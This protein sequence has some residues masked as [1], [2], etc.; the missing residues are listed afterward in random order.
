MGALVKSLT[1]GSDSEL[2][3]DMGITTG[4]YA[5]KGQLHIDTAKLKEA[6]EAD[7][8]KVLSAFTQKSS[9]GYSAYATTEQT[10]QRFNE[11]GVLWR[12]S[13]VMTKNL[14]TIGKK[15]ALITLRGQPQ[16]HRT[17]PT[18]NTPRESAA[19]RIR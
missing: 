4:N 8:S 16:Q 3:S 17:P 15:G 12:I 11:S 6:L 9:A 5:E 10:Q 18:R 1:G 7:A 14:S 2:L 19:W 13:D